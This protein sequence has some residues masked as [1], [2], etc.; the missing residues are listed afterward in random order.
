MIMSAIMMVP[1]V[2]VILGYMLI[3]AFQATQCPPDALFWGGT[4]G[5]R[6]ALVYPWMGSAFGW[7]GCQM[8]AGRFERQGRQLAGC[9]DPALLRRWANRLLPVAILVSAFFTIDS[10]F[11]EFCVLRDHISLRPSLFSAAKTYEWSS[12]QRLIA[13]CSGSVHGN[14]RYS[15]KVVMS[16]GRMIDLAYTSYSGPPFKVVVEAVGKA[17]RNV[18]YSYDASGVRAWCDP[19]YKQLMLKPPTDG[20]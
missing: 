13:T 14:E 4:K 17:L 3:N 10:A 7:L 16:D 9:Y 20:L 8:A 6:L 11:T 1:G 19:P 18:P 15:Y 2:A 12:V 5:G